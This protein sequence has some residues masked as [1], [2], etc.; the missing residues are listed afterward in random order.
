[1][2][3]CSVITYLLLLAWD[4]E[5]STWDSSSLANKHVESPFFLGNWVRNMREFESIR[6]VYI[7]IN[8]FFYR[9]RNAQIEITIPNPF[10]RTYTHFNYIVSDAIFANWKTTSI[11]IKFRYYYNSFF[12]CTTSSGYF[13][14]I[15]DMYSF[16]VVLSMQH[17][18][19]FENGEA[20]F[21]KCLQ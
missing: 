14:H 8:F 16:V 11:S 2:S 19:M 18:N 17:R 4:C 6:I 10:A 15:Y 13:F 3:F 21:D 12:F 9:R 7:Y 1:M 5:P 20:L